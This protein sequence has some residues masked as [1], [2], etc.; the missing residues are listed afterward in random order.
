M[1]YR[2]ILFD[3]DGT[4]LDFNRSWLPVYRHA[5]LEFA[6]GDDE[7]AGCLLSD[8]GYDRTGE[9]F[10]GG[11]LL[12]A[13]NNRQ[14]A[15]AWA[16]RTGRGHSIEVLSRRL[17]EIFAE[18]GARHATAVEGLGA[19]LQA[20]TDDGYR[21]GVATADSQQGIVATLRAFDVLRQF[22]FLAGFDSGHGVKPEA[23]MV[24]AFCR[25][26]SLDP[27]AVVVVG[28]NR[29]DIEMGR[30]AGA[31]LCVGVLTG[32]STRADLEPIADLV[33]EDIGGLP[34]ALRDRPA[35]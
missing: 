4:L 33:L 29:H 12:A 13:G 18:L 6:D 2:G 22:D 1:N 17:G 21:L 8:H 23:G 25:Q 31:G 9:R 16:R 7:L 28:D 27:A 24:L 32:T 34:D 14:I 5:A 19:T 10:V 30:N 15:E 20:L 26:L 3:K 35:G 11:S